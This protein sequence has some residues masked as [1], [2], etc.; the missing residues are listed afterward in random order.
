MDRLDVVR[1]GHGALDLEVQ[2]N[3]E[4]VLGNRRQIE[5]DPAGVKLEGAYAKLPRY[6]KDADRVMDLEQRLLWCMQN[7]QG[8]DTADVVKRRFGGPGRQSDME[9][10]VAFIANKSSG[11]KIAVTLDHPKEQEAYAVGE[12]IFFRRSGQWDFACA[13]CHAEDNRRIRLQG[14]PNLTKPGKPVQNVMSP[15]PT[16]RVSQ[17][18]TRTMQHRLWDCFRQMRWAEPDYLADGVTALTIYLNKNAEGGILR[19]PPSSDSERGG[20]DA[21]GTRSGGGAD[22]TPSGHGRSAA[23]DEG[24]SRDGRQVHQGHV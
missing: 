5:L 23:G 9:D 15:W 2:R 1:L 11:M 24:R 17:S 22:G 14:L 20:R 19:S 21:Q 8:L 16:Y 4:P 6:F 10:L 7:L 13:T 18:Q 3:D 12:A